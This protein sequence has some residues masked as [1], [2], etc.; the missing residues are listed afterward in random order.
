MKLLASR[1]RAPSAPGLCPP[2]M[3]GGRSAA[4]LGILLFA[5]FSVSSTFAGVDFRQ[6]ANNDPAFGLGNLHWINSILQR[7]NSVYFEGM[8]VLQRVLLTSIPTTAGNHHSLLFR[9]QFTKGQVHAY[10]FLL[11]YAQAQADDG[12]ALGVTIVL[13]PCG[14]EIGPP[15]SMAATC[16]ALHNGANSLDAPVP[17]DAF[18]SKD[19]PTSAKIAASEALHR[20]RPMRISGH[21]P[22]SN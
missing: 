1:A 3:C 14:A 9:H 13:N 16:A 11:S 2:H 10:D 17:D 5:A 6:S 18:I 19:G 8:S 15:A 22:C 21:A 20:N 4:R 12:A 7:N